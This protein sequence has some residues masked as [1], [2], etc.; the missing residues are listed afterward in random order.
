MKTS[1]N[2]NLLYQPQEINATLTNI[3]KQLIFHSPNYFICH[4]N[5]TLESKSFLTYF[6]DLME[7]Q[8]L[9]PSH[10]GKLSCLVS[11]SFDSLNT[12]RQPLTPQLVFTGCTNKLYFL[13]KKLHGLL[14]ISATNCN[15]TNFNLL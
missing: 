9:L 2:T 1:Q 8:E 4:L 13:Q 10:K 11:S 5:K 12:H 14:S 7:L 3:V 15:N 6:N